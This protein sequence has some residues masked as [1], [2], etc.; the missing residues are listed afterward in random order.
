MRSLV[1]ALRERERDLKERERDQQEVKIDNTHTHT[2]TQRERRRRGGTEGGR[3]ELDY[4]D[5]IH[6]HAHKH[7]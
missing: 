7:T 4:M 6:K 5:N 2:H 3:D 1:C